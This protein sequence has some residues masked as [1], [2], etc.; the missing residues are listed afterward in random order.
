VKGDEGKTLKSFGP[1]QF[2]QIWSQKY[3]EEYG[4]G[5]INILVQDNL[6]LVM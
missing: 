5:D 2:C 6:L 3:D 4:E 1:A